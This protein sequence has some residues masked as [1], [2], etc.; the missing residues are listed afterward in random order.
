MQGNSNVIPITLR[1]I[2]RKNWAISWN[3]FPHSLLVQD[4]L[5]IAQ[6]P[7]DFCFDVIIAL[8]PMAYK[9]FFSLGKHGNS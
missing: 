1:P 6:I 2:L 5:V 8:K 7:V 9:M 3:K 4:P